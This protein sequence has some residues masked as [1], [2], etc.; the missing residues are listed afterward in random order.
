MCS[1][2]AQAHLRDF[3]VKSEASIENGLLSD[4]E[5]KTAQSDVKEAA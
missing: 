4:S 2:K 1:D 5:E 3:A